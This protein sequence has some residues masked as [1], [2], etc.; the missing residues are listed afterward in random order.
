VTIALLVLSLLAPAAQP[1]PSTL[2]TARAR[3]FL[4]EWVLTFERGGR[5]AGQTRTVAITEVGGKVAAELA[6]GRGG[7]IAVTD[8]SMRDETLVLKFDQI[9]SAGPVDVIL[10]PAEITLTR[11]GDTLIATFAAGTGYS[12]GTGRKKPI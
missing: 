8:I 5:G 3:A 12:T 9:G 10:E 11:A 4:G 6:G 2:D 1:K 7:T